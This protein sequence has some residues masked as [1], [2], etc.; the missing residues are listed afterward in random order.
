MQWNFQKETRAPKLR[1]A[2]EDER[3]GA[4]NE[5]S[6]DITLVPEANWKGEKAGWLGTSWDRGG[7]CAIKDLVSIWLWCTREH[8]LNMTICNNKLSGW[9]KK[10][11]GQACTKKKK[12]KLGYGLVSAAGLIHCNFW[13]LTEPLP[14]KT[15][16][17]KRWNAPEVQP[18]ASSVRAIPLW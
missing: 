13:M 12:K 7:V 4:A 18:S 14:W 1:M 3:L 17:A 6:M 10:L 8:G 2:V 16:S 5:L 15:H 9:L 11:Q